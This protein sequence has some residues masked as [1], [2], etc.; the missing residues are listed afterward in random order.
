MM[1]FAK[2]TAMVGILT[3]GAISVGASLGAAEVNK[4]IAEGQAV[5]TQLGADA[6]AVSYW[7]NTPGGWQVVTTVDS[8]S[9]RDTTAEHHAV[10]RFSATLLPGQVQLISVPVA[11]GEEPHVLR[12]RRTDDGIDVEQVAG[13]ST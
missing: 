2:A 4:T 7:V 5:T 13:S 11:I 9:G 6:A 3:L 1:S 10:V 12:I 8:V